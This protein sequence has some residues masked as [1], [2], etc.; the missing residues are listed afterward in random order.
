MDAINVFLKTNQFKENSLSS[1]CVFSW[2]CVP[3]LETSFSGIN[4]YYRMLMFIFEGLFD[5]SASANGFHMD[6]LNCQT[7]SYCSLKS[8]IWQPVTPYMMLF[9]S[10]ILHLPLPDA[11]SAEIL[12]RKGKAENV[13]KN[14]PIVTEKPEKDIICKLQVICKNY[15]EHILT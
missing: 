15:I 2:L 5:P 12:K 3:V 9:I 11:I 14:N 7:N 6:S 8:S 13:G 4:G 10:T 1:K